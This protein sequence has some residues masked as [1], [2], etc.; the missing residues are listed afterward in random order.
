MLEIC[1]LKL[2]EAKAYVPPK[3]S[4]SSTRTATAFGH[5]RERR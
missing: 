5:L 2:N 1:K 4:R 3:T